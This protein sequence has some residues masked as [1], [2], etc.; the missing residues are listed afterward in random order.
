MKTTLNTK[1]LDAATAGSK[2]CLDMFDAMTPGLCLRVTA[3]KKSWCF[4]F[5]PPGGSARTRLGFGTYPATPLKDARTKAE[6]LR[7]MVE[8]GRDPRHIAAASAPKTIAQLIQDRLDMEVNGKLRS[9]AEIA[10]RY[11]K[12]VAPIIGSVPVRDFRVDPHYNKVVNPIVKAGKNRMAE[13]VHVDLTA[14]FNFAVDQEVVE[15]SRM[16]GR[17]KRF[18]KYVPCDRWLSEQ[19]I[20]TLWGSLPTAL[21]RAPK[22]QRAIR[23]MLAT[24]QRSGEVIGMSHSE[25]NLD[26]ALWTIPAARAKNGY[27]HVVPL[28]ALAM[29]L[30]REA[31]REAGGEYLFPREKEDRPKDSREVANAVD[32][33]RLLA[34]DGA[35]DKFGI[36]YW[37]PHDLR[38]TVGTH[39]SK[40]GVS[41]GDIGQVLNHRTTTKSTVTQQVYNQNTYL[42]EKREALDKWGAFLAAL[43]GVE[44][45]LRVAA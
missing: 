19:E 15:F 29:K 4:V 34:K 45:G 38:R 5:T 1:A 25:L 14:L 42:K 32:Y 37:T 21:G 30:V 12:Y 20:V 7:G 36:P 44:T 43:V 6:E 22:V 8:Q 24:G 11:A 41:D 33:V 13:M 18:E 3:A 10:W 23:L 17:K 2:P 26:K 27:E 16:A 39:M 9:A 35:A 31:V 40:L 28:S